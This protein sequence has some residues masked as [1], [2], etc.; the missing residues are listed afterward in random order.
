MANH[1]RSEI[2][3]FY[4]LEAELLDGRKLRDGSLATLD[5]RADLD[6][7]VRIR[8]LAEEGVLG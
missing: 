5:E 4:Y 3:D 7:V 6:T 1:L 2:E 8:A